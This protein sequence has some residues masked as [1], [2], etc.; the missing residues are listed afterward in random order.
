M[1]QNGNTHGDGKN[2]NKPNSYIFQKVVKP[3]TGLSE[4]YQTLKHRKI[5]E[6]TNQNSLSCECIQF[7]N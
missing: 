6:I 4:T 5:K 3:Y 1:P 2:L 7:K